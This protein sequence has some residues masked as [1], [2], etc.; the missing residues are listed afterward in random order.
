M[1]YKRSRIAARWLL[2]RHIQL[3]CQRA[4][5]PGTVHVQSGGLAVQLYDVEEF[6]PNSARILLDKV[7]ASA[8]VLFMTST[9]GPGA[10]PNSA[11]K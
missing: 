8:M 11:S 4:S 10:P 9:Y 2:Q 7:E 3:Q 1:L 6:D 5:Q